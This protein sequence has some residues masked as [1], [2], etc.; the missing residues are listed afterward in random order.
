M[1]DP[2]AENQE[3]EATETADTES[4]GAAATDAEP[5]TEAKAGDNAAV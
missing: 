2:V 3:V 5:A 4:S 1:S